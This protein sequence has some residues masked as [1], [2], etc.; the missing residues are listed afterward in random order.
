MQVRVHVNRLGRVFARIVLIQ[1]TDLQWKVITRKHKREVQ[2][3]TVLKAE[4]FCSW[5]RFR[6]APNPS[7]GFMK[8]QVCLPMRWRFEVMASTMYAQL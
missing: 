8:V 5:T 1:V 6:R 3:S 2:P 4:L 7:L